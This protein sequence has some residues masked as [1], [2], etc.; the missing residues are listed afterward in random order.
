MEGIWRY[1]YVDVTRYVYK[2]LEYN[3]QKNYFFQM[4]KFRNIFADDKL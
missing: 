4:D 2:I 1:T 3:N